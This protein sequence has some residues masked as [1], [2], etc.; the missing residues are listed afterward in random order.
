MNEKDLELEELNLE[1]IMK[2]FGAEDI[3]SSY[4]EDTQDLLDS[5]AAIEGQSTA[6][7]PEETKA[8]VE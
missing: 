8:F 7:V 3:H 2:E 6:E 4:Q 1:E 5:I